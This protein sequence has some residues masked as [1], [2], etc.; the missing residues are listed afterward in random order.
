MENVLR[1]NDSHF[2]KRNRFPWKPKLLEALRHTAKGTY[3]FDGNMY[4][5]NSRSTYVKFADSEL[6]EALKVKIP[7]F[8]L[9]GKRVFN[10]SD[11][12]ALLRS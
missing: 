10:M 2:K 7:L 6:V 12:R 4:M 5:K 1:L 11:I 3:Y 8:K 9:R